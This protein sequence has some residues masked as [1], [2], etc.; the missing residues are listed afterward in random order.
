VSKASKRE[1][2]RLNREARRE[3]ELADERRR[4]QFRTARNI[5]LLLLPLVALFVG[6]QVLRGDDSSDANPGVAC[7]D[8]EPEQP[9]T[10]Q[11]Y[12]TPPEPT[13]DPNLQYTA[14]LETSCG[15][16][17]I[18]LDAVAAPQ[19]TNN[20]VFLARAGYY[21]GTVFHRVVDDFVVQ[22]GDP[23]GTGTGGPGYTIPDEFP[24]G[25]PE[26]TSFPVGAVAMA[27]SG[28]G[29]TGSQFFIVTGAGGQNLNPPDYSR[30]GRVIE[31]ER[32]GERLESFA[33][34]DQTPSRPL[35]LFNVTI[36]EAPVA[37]ATTTTAAAAP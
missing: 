36:S 23:T 4:R 1:R 15:D 34:P 28:P 20:F 30:F 11:T 24:Q 13:L 5:G 12:P 17:E 22:G 16:I 7:T 31:G 37:A 32:V 26:G 2:Q 3:A 9:V 35:Y 33:N 18:A 29:T 10:P 25:E 8:R 14:V 6:L 21:N 27:N 19:T